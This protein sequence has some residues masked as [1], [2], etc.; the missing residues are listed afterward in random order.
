[1]LGRST[2]PVAITEH[3]SGAAVYDRIRQA[4]TRVVDLAR[5]TRASPARPLGLIIE[6]VARMLGL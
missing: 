1:M 2:I 6:M 5:V 4:T 3:A